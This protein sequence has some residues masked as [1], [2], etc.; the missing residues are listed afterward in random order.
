MF[1]PQFKKW[2]KVSPLKSAYREL[3]IKMKEGGIWSAQTDKIKDTQDLGTQY[4]YSRVDKWQILFRKF[5]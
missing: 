3:H 4:A 1:D 5:C 2:I